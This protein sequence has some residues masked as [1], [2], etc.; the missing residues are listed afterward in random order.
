MA[1]GLY[2]SL[3]RFLIFRK[4]SWCCWIIFIKENLIVLI[5]P[6]YLNT[7]LFIST[8]KIFNFTG[9]SKTSKKLCSNVLLEYFDK[10]I[11][12]V[13]FDFICVSLYFEM[14]YGLYHS[15]NRFLIFR[16][17][18]W[19]CW[20]IFIKENLIVLICPF[21]LN[22]WLFISTRK[23]FNF[24]GYSKTSKKLCSNVLLEYF[25]KDNGAVKWHP[26]N[27][28]TKVISSVK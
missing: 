22:T 25:D 10:D 23:I 17:T 21:Y 18:S 6:F 19:C 16:K 8:R 13:I 28:K 14:A 2:H 5:C 9:Y 11:G 20:I 4:T 24:T 26:Y 12:A 27:V 7:W 1:Y 15:L 3:N